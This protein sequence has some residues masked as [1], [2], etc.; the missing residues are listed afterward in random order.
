MDSTTT[1]NFPTGAYKGGTLLVVNSGAFATQY[2]VPD[3][4]NKDPYMY[5]RTSYGAFFKQWAKIGVT[6]TT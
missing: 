6:I 4:L 1:K 3:N 5:I 2:F